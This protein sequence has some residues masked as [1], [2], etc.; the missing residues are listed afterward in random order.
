MTT[1]YYITVDFTSQSGDIIENEQDEFYSALN[2]ENAKELYQACIDNLEEE[3]R[4]II[5]RHEISYQDIK[6]ENVTYGY[7]LFREG[8]DDDDGL[9]TVEPI[10]SFSMSYNHVHNLMELER[11][12]ELQEESEEEGKQGDDEEL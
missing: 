2:F 9:M 4:T 8:V 7:S 11:E 5:S 6:N 12:R 10:D 3:M 1:R